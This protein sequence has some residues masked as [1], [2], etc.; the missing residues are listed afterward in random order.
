MIGEGIMNKINTYNGVYEF[1]AIKLFHGRKTINRSICRDNLIT[2]K[3]ILDRQ[4]IEFG[5]IFGTLLGAVRESNFIEYDEDVDVF[6]L[7]ENKDIFLSILF[8][9]RDVG[10]N[11]VRYDSQLL[12]IMK[13]D[14]YIDIY[15]FK[16]NSIGKRTCLEF[17]IKSG[18]MESLVDINFLDTTFKTVNNYI[19]FLEYFYGKDWEMPKKYY[20]AKSNSFRAKIKMRIKTILPKFIIDR[21]RKYKTND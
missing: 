5:I 12:S 9:L 16:K 13:D 14:D 4:N 11:V 1:S 20:H 2:F 17:S 3:K 6:I 21:I 8:E 7:E 18:C 15:F 19:D 10:L